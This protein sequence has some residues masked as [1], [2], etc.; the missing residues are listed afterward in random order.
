[1]SDTAQRSPYEVIGEEGVA[2]LVES[3]YDIVELNP[4]FSRLRAMHGADL[5]PIRKGLT[6][7]LVGW[8]GGPR[9]WL[10]QGQCI[11][12][13]HRPYAIDSGLADER[14][15]AVRT[16]IAEATLDAKLGE[17]MGDAL[18]QIAQ[19]MVNRSR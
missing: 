17:K 18:A 12:S 10:E 19:A 5:G 13:V 9:D 3:F 6:R 1:M 14:S 15:R 7:F 2:A 16:A 8:L 11:M 4:D